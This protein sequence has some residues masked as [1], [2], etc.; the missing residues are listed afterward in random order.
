VGQSVDPGFAA[1][2][3]KGMLMEDSRNKFLDDE[4]PRMVQ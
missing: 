4:A 1:S 2:G 3:R